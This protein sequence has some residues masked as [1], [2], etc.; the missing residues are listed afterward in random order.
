MKKNPAPPSV[1]VEEQPYPVPDNWRWVETRAV[2]Q[3]ISG[4][5][6]SPED[7]NVEGKGIPYILGA[8]NLNGNSFIM[9]RWIENPAVESQR[10]DILLTVKGTIGKL[11]AQKEDRLCISR[12]IM[13]IRPGVAFYDRYAYYFFLYEG[14]TLRQFS[15]GLIPGISRKNVLSLAVPLPPLPE[16]YRIVDRL[17]SLLTKLDGAREKARAVLDG[18]EY[19]RAA[20]LQRAFTGEL[21]A[22]WRAQHGVSLNSWRKANLSEVATL[23]TGLMKGK[24]Y[25]DGEKTVFMPYLRVANVQDGFLNL[26]A[27]KQIEVSEALVSRYL[28]KVGDVL[29]TEG[30][31]FDKLGRGTVWRGEIKDCLHQN[32]IF[33]ARTDTTVLLPDF[34]SL[35]AGSLYGKRYFLSCSKQIINLASINSTQLKKFPVILPGIE[36]QLEIVH[37]INSALSREEQAKESAERVLETVDLMKKAILGRAF[38][39]LLGTNRPTEISGKKR[40]P[41]P[42]DKSPGV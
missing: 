19:R 29:F 18:C 38:R 1:P 36:E 7:C 12:Q 39:G 31:D 42:M 14:D 33:V 37:I 3:L 10:G 23:Q 32:H 35:Q 2:I 17:E 8:S 4:R 40:P 11:Y 22:K 6:V 15:H 20:I 16:Q 27:I 34:L 13:A 25:K 28:L 26:D 9:E 24:R 30:G 5:D 41:G 21:T